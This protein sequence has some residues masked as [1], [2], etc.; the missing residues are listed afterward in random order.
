[1]TDAAYILDIRSTGND[2]EYPLT[3]PVTTIGRSADNDLVLDDTK[4]SRRHARL[5]IIEGVLYITDLESSNGTTVNGSEITPG[6]PFSLSENDNVSIGDSTLSVRLAQSGVEVDVSAE[7]IRGPVITAD[8][9]PV[10]GNGAILTGERIMILSAGMLMILSVFL[11]WVGA[12]DLLGDGFRAAPG[13]MV[14]IFAG[15]AGVV[16][17]A[18]VC[19]GAF[20]LKNR[21]RAFIVLCAGILSL[22]AVLVIISIGTLPLFSGYARTL[23]V[24]RE[25]FYI[26]VLDAIV[27]IVL[28]IIF[29][30]ARNKNNG[31]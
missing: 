29:R 19:A 7:S 28:G 18:G 3:Q 22:L 31:L 30:K 27:L 26:Y 11:P 4:V 23:M 15:A 1:M 6:T 9:A 21:K 8:T 5:E 13:F 24:V 20:L 25:G 14:S 17:G 12:S 16:C 2:G 10:P